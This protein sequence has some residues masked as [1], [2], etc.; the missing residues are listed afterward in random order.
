MN[1]GR[2]HR[3][4]GGGL[5]Q[6]AD[7]GQG[8]RGGGWQVAFQVE[9]VAEGNREEGTEEPRGGFKHAYRLLN[10]RPTQVV[11]TAPPPEPAWGLWAPRRIT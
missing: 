6:G 9:Q 1:R 7:S 10:P 4:L 5:G 2:G 11:A 8:S 3:R